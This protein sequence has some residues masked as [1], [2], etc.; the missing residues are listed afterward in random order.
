LTVRVTA[1]FRLYQVFLTLLKIDI[2]FA[3][4]LL[5]MSGFFLIT[6]LYP[7]SFLG[8]V[9]MVLTVVRAVC[10]WYGITHEH[11][12]LVAF[13][14]VLMPLEPAYIIY[15]IVT[16]LDPAVHSLYDCSYVPCKLYSATGVPLSSV[17]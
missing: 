9:L 4:S 8:I 7:P 13:F 15:E 16:L 14:L 1:L 2:Q 12:G 17:G 3:I 11:R 6:P 5:L 10:G